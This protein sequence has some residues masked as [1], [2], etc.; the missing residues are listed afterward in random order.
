MELNIHKR[1]S[2]E[3]IEA[4]QEPCKHEMDVLYGGHKSY[5]NTD[6]ML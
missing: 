5:I 1:R 4:P 6:L 2:L 3:C